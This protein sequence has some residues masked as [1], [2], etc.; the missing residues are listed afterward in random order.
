MIGYLAWI[1]ATSNYRL[2]HRIEIEIT[3]I[4]NHFLTTFVTTY[5]IMNSLN[6]TVQGFIK[7][8]RRTTN[9]IEFS[10]STNMTVIN[11]YVY[12][13]FNTYLPSAFHIEFYSDKTNRILRLDDQILSS[14]LSPFQFDSIDNSEEFI[15]SMDCVFLFIV[16]DSPPMNLISSGEFI[17]NAVPSNEV[18]ND[19][20][21]INS[22]LSE[23]YSDNDFIRTMLPGVIGDDHHPN[24]ISSSEFDDVFL[25]SLPGQ[26][27]PNTG[28]IL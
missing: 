14:E 26:N 2:T 22:I 25:P 21:F 15:N 8:G 5:I 1:F 12:Y 23:D 7:L 4:I 16:E 13:W 6:R 24:T 11:H 28:R 27:L 19:L 20:A 10:P 9:L 17:N 18:D 3:L